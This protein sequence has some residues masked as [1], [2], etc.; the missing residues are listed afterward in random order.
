MN[1]SWNELF[2]LKDQCMKTSPDAAVISIRRNC[3]VEVELGRVGD[4]YARESLQIRFPDDG[5]H[6]EP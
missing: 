3:A 5:N 4:L 6:V 1:H 2:R